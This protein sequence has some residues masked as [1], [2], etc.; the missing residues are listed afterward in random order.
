MIILHGNTKIYMNTIFSTLITYHLGYHVT[1]AARTCHKGLCDQKW[2]WTK[3]NINQMIQQYR[4]QMIFSTEGM[5]YIKWSNF[6]QV[7]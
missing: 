2:L 1:L 5:I 4:K 6:D 3:E 7:F